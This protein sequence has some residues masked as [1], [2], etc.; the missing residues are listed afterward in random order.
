[1]AGVK[2]RSGRKSTTDEEKR[3]RIID[4]AWE[5]VNQFLHDSTIDIKLR[6]EMAS[7]L[8]TKD[9][10]TQV[11]GNLSHVVEMGEIKVGDKPLTFDIGGNN[12]THTT[13]VVGNAGEVIPD[14]PQV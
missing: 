13:E 2:G 10:P 6:A 4:K 5:I 12:G 9:M 11:E 14:N 1:M 7:K 3:L 8:V